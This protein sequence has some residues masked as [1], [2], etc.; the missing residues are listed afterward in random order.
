MMELY[1]NELVDLLVHKPRRSHGMQRDHLEDAT[2]LNTRVD[3]DGQVHI[4]NLTEEP[5]D[6]AQDLLHL[7]E[8]GNRQR[9][10]AATAMNGASSRSHL[11]MTIKIASMN[12]ETHEQLHGKIL[13][14]DLAGSER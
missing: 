7:L 8:R 10:V 13:L 3:K 14:C 9:T 4:D 1:R 6:T 11:I 5:C 12:R 2:A